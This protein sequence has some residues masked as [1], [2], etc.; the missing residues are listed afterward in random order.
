VDRRCRS[1][2]GQQAGSKGKEEEETF[3]SPKMPQPKECFD[4]AK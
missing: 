1:G 3:A 4:F 2:V